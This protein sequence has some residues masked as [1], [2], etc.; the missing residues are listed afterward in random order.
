MATPTLVYFKEANTNIVANV[1]ISQYMASGDT[2]TS[3]VVNGVTP[4]TTPALVATL[5]SATD[6]PAATISLTG[7]IAGTSYGIELLVTTAAT[8]FTILL[9]VN[10]QTAA[11][12][13]FPYTTQNPDAFQDL[14]GE[15][16]AGSAAVGTGV[17][18]FNNDVDPSG[19]SVVWELLAKDGTVFSSGNAFSYTVQSTGFSNTVFA[20]AVINAPSDMAPSLEG[21]KYQIRW[22]LSLN[23]PGP[24]GSSANVTKF[25]SAE[26]VT[27]VG[28]T[29]VPLGTEPIVVLQGATA[30]AN[31]V[32]DQL[33][34]TVTIQ[35]YYQNSPMSDATII[36][37]PN[38][39]SS[40][41]PVRTAN[42]WL[43]SATIDTSQILVNAMAPY[44]LIW[45][46]S[47][48]Q[49]PQIVFSENADFWVINP[50]MNQAVT[51]VKAMVNKAR[52]TLYGRPDLLFPPSVIL[53]WLRRG[54][55][56]FNGFQGYFTA[57][58]M[59][60]A[61]GPIREYWL[62][63]T[64]LMALRSQYL[65]EGE[66]AFDF[67]GQAISLKVD[68]TQYLDA[69]AN[70]IQQRLNNELPNFKTQLINK[71][72]T[73]GD[74]SVD[75]TQLQRGAMGTVGV[76]ASPASF[77]GRWPYGFGIA[78]MF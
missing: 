48:S 53:T 15:M 29:N 57:F 73:S 17:F 7:G 34:D 8:V 72:N 30:L 27:I 58:T 47:N 45:R 74:G 62:L 23:L 66:K 31:L 22:T 21:Q 75:P 76:W 41:T 33:F 36:S 71:G 26:E 54:A 50:S 67:E 24:G 32:V 46:Y 51:D 44:T 43:Y 5:T 25:Y 12:M 9:A 35:L 16:L 2:L 11:E 13:L 59:V 61:Q 60:N 78:G 42:G 3:V 77:S 40:F 68:R 69:A 38:V 14:V 1:G 63:C 10:V 20:K 4:A 6:N 65:A 39:A 18:A 49:Y 55:D 56:M 70:Q 52:T 19:G 64:E 37:A 28:L